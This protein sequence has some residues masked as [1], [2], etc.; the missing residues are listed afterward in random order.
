MSLFLNII[1]ISDHGK[2]TRL[3]ENLAID[4]RREILDMFLHAASISHPIIVP[5][6]MAGKSKTIFGI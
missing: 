2:S 4:D 1:G 5:V 6:S 3:K